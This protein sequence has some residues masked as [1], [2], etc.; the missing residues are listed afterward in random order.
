[1]DPFTYFFEASQQAHKIKIPLII[2]PPEELTRKPVNLGDHLR[3]RRIELKL[4][5]KD[6]AARLGVTTSTI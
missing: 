5:Q 2:P 6:V 4:Y 1:V 3:R